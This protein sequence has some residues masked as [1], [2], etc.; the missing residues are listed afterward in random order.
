M[1]VK[2]T[3][4]DEAKNFIQQKL[5]D[6]EINHGVRILLAV[7]SGSRAWGFPSKNSDYDVRFVYARTTDEYLS[8]KQYRDVIETDIT[9]EI[10]LGNQLDLNGWDI[11]KALQLALKSNP[12]LIEWLKS[13]I[14]YYADIDIVDNLLT[15]TNEISD[16]AAIENHYYNI[17]MNA[18]QQM[19]VDADKANIKQY[20]YALRPT[21][22]IQWLRSFHNAPPMDMKTLCEGLTIDTNLLKEISDLI[23]QKASSKE[24]DAMHHFPLID[25]FIAQVLSTTAE[26]NNKVVSEEKVNKA[27]KLFRKII[28]D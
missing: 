9:D 3:I 12:V 10:V 24:H 7:E 8:V 13:P 26:R 18:W 25:L 27:N 11:R 28:E 16:I 15:F 17:A 23:T 4:T 6:I 20:C 22:A 19:K 14:K 1:L 2:S 21:L 5:K